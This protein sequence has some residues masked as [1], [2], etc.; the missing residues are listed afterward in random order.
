MIT[1]CYIKGRFDFGVGKCAVVI[2]EGTEIKYKVGWVVPAEFK[3]GGE[4]TQS[5]QFNCEILAAIYAVTWCK[6]NGKKIINVYANTSSCQ[7][8]YYRRE[9]PESRAMMGKAF[10]EAAEGV[11][12]YADFV[13]KVDDNEF[14]RLVNELA[15]KAR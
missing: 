13:P 12:V 10:N 1:E 14:N 3:Y 8:W 6:Q 9:F 15:E 5:D 4:V 11:D 7:K 2:V